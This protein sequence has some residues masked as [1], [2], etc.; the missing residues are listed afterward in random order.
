M[1]S[2]TLLIYPQAGIKFEMAT[3]AEEL[4]KFGDIMRIEGT[5][6]VAAVV[7]FFDVRAAA[8]AQEALGER[9]THEPQFGEVTLPIS[10]VKRAGFCASGSADVASIRY[11]PGDGLTVTFFDTRVAEKV[12]SDAEV[13]EGD[14]EDTSDDFLDIGRPAVDLEVPPG[15]QQE[16]APEPPPGLAI[17]KE[18]D[19]EP[20][21]G[22]EEDLEPPPGLEH[23]GDDGKDVAA[24]WGEVPLDYSNQWMNQWPSE[25]TLALARAQAVAMAEENARRWRSSPSTPPRPMR[26]VSPSSPGEAARRLEPL[27]V[28]GE[29]YPKKLPMQTKP[30]RISDMRLSQ[31]SL[32]D[33]KEKRTTLCL[34]PLPADMCK[35]GV[36][37]GVLQK[38]GICATVQRIKMVRSRLKPLGYA[39]VK[40]ASPAEVSTITRLFH[41]RLVGNSLPISVSF[42]SAGLCGTKIH[43]SIRAEPQ[44]ITVASHHYDV[45]SQGSDGATSRS[46]DDESTQDPSSSEAASQVDADEQLPTSAA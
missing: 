8:A 25:E 35:E 3:V 14:N 39:I 24:Y 7:S 36:L 28:A 9:C 27:V 21:P 32:K 41:G 2:N 29:A 11:V 16:L 12:R 17:P 23:I 30:Q 13:R 6:D 46:E 33:S 42:I 18:E 19:L 22:L 31:I 38:N 43:P 37:Q 5:S 40:A 45:P 4:Q 44:R 34:K 10:T 15:L 20:P 1:A 26:V